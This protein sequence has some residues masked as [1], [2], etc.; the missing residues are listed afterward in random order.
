MTNTEENKLTMYEAVLSL[1]N[2]KKEIKE[3][4]PALDKPIWELKNITKNIRSGDKTWEEYANGDRSDLAKAED[5]L[6]EALLHIG[7]SLNVYAKRNGNNDLLSLC[8]FN[9]ST[10]SLLSEIELYN[11]VNIII[12]LANEN[13]KDLK[14]YGIN[15]F[16]I[17][18]LNNKLSEFKIHSM[19]PE[20]NHNERVVK[21]WSLSSLFD[22]A[23][24]VLSE[25]F[26]T[27]LDSIRDNKPDLYNE[28]I[29]KRQLKDIGKKHTHPVITNL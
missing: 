3:S 18:D 10:L 22:Q 14:D 28:Y 11:K 20:T 7:K 29:N 27:L 6:I 23:D 12:E 2:S 25:E 8:D 13:L 16:L 26:D 5:N 9:I 17:N 4:I 21:R 15:A 24:G 19:I 1:M